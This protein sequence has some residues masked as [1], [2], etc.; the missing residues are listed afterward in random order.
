MYILGIET[1]CDET[2]V[3]ISKEREILSNVTVS[4]IIHSEYGG[5]VPEIASRE[6]LYLINK[7]HPVNNYKS[8]Q[9]SL[10]FPVRAT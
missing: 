2:S 6:H 3:A 4:Q 7:V 10:H 1:S 8:V 5:V 9:N